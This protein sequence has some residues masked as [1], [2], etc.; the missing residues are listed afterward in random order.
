[1]GTGAGVRHRF[2]TLVFWLYADNASLHPR[3]DARVD[4]MIEV[5]CPVTGAGPLS[6]L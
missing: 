5:R 6:W 4:K 3:L 1:M 2:R